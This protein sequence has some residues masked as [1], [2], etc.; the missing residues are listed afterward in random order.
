LLC[1][2][3][4]PAAGGRAVFSFDF[5]LLLHQTVELEKKR[6]GYTPFFIPWFSWD[7]GQGRSFYGS[8][9]F[10]F[11]FYYYQDAADR[12]GW[13]KPVLLPELA[14]AVLRPLSC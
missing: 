7:N 2:I 8:G 3:P 1:L 4:A 9:A 10:S 6:G 5:G 11:P 14:Q 13:A 12:E